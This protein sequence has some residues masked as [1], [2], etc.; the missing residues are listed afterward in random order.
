[1]AHVLV[2]D[3]ERAIRSSIKDILELENY[4]V[5]E[6]VDGKDALSKLQKNNYDLL[7]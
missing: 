3:D 6:A 1:M 7:I 5:D 2:A 4:K